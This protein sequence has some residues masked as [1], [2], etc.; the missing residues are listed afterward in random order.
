[1]KMLLSIAYFGAISNVYST[2]M[3]GGSF[4]VCETPQNADLT[5]QQYEGLVWLQVK[6]VGSHGE[7]GNNQN[8]LS[9]DTWDAVF[10]LK[11]KGIANAGDPDVEL[12]R[13]AG[14]PGQV[15]LRSMGSARNHNNYAFKIERNDAPKNG[16]PTCIYNRGLVTGPRTQ[17]GRNEDFDLENYTL[18]MQQEQITVEA[19][20]ISISGAPPAG[21]LNGTY[22]F[23]PTAVGG[24]APYSYEWYGTDLTPF[25]I[26]ID[27]ATGKMTSNDLA[28]TGTVEGIIRVTDN[29]NAVASMRVNIIIS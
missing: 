24:D 12:V 26:T 23:T 3:A 2:T 16:S 9:Y 25:G 21:V 15:A 13:I 4:Y 29:N 7:T 1:M 14:D 10:E 5:V 17:N 28:K 22:L 8:I 20:P 6:G 27:D 19:S 18:G 11:G